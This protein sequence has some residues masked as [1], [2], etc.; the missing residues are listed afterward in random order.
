MDISA[1][2]SLCYI[3]VTLEPRDFIDDFQGSL[4]YP[5]GYHIVFVNETY[6]LQIDLF[7]FWG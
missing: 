2:F 1:P 7:R 4:L 6:L 3:H 5:S